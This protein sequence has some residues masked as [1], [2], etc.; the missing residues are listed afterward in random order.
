MRSEKRR[1]AVAAAAALAL[2]LGSCAFM[3]E[4][5]RIEIVE[6]DLAK[7]ADGT[8]VG[9]WNT[10]LVSATVSVDTLSHGISGIDILR[11]ECGK[12]RPAEAIV[13]RVVAAQRLTVDTVSGATGSSKVILRA[14]QDALEKAVAAGEATP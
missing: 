10:A 5:D 11:H 1:R 3:G 6:P 8:W 2:T 9:E 13:D 14:I 7:A 12:G 4:I